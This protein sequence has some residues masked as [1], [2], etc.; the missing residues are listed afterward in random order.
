MAEIIPTE[1]LDKEGPGAPPRSN[2]ELIFEAPWESRLFG[3]TMSLHKDGLFYWEEFRQLLIDEIG[4]WDAGGHPEEEWSY[5][6][7]WAAA[8]ER[9]LAKKGLC[10]PAELETRVDSFAARPH[11]HDH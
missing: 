4:T 3:M 7:H 10:K 9:L 5:Y 2:G 11:G 8:F 1:I 6:Q